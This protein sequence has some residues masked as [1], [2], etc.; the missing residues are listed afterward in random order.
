[1]ISI[2]RVILANEDDVRMGL[3]NDITFNATSFLGMPAAFG[4]RAYFVHSLLVF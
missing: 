3:A 1:M 4:K 2:D